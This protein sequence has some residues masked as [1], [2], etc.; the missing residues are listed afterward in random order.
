[1]S[2]V[3]EKLRAFAKNLKREIVVLASAIADPRTPLAAKLFGA[4]VIAYAL[5]PIDLIPDFIPV[6]GFLDEL[7]LL[8]VCLWALKRMIPVGVLNEHKARVAADTRLPV[9]KTAAAVIA[10]IW[11]VSLFAVSH[12]L[13]EW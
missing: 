13:W 9:S 10:A 1:M 5:S 11:L 6:I 7:I 4:A 12:W 8:P 3:L 2:S